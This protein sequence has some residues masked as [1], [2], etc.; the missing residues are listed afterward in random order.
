MSADVS[1]QSPQLARARA[2][3]A[4]AL[5]TGPNAELGDTD[6]LDYGDALVILADVLPPLPLPVPFETEQPVT[7]GATI[8]ALI[9]AA[10]V[11]ADPAEAARIAEAARALSVP[12]P[13]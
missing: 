7:R 1:P 2:I 6:V 11:A 9:V 13:A 5:R 12:A 8:A 10:T 3:L 4:A